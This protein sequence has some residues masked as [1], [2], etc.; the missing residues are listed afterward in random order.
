MRP[1][2][3]LLSIA[4]L[5]SLAALARRNN[6][7]LLPFLSRRQLL[8]TL[9]LPPRACEEYQSYANSKW[10]K[11]LSLSLPVCLLRP[12]LHSSA[13]TVCSCLLWGNELNWSLL[14]PR[15][16]HEQHPRDEG[17]DHGRAGHV[18][19]EAVVRLSLVL[20]LCGHRL[21]AE[22]QRL[23]VVVGVAAKGAVERR[24]REKIK[25]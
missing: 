21:E 20:H 19:R 8:P 14:S 17:E 9:L 10:R 4:A 6:N 22:N 23:E 7:I 1:S 25:A 15:D 5:L 11:P 13:F 24:R 12:P 16:Q 18:V 2:D 3:C